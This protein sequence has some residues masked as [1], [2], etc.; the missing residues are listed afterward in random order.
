MEKY[1]ASIDLGASKI[2]VAVGERTRK[3]VKIRAYCEV[4]SNGMNRG[5]VENPRV[6]SNEVKKAISIIKSEYGIEVKKAIV[7]IAGHSLKCITTDPT[8]TQRD[9]TSEITY[10]EIV[11]ITKGM[12]DMVMED[13]EKVFCAI[14]QSYNVDNNMSVIQPEG[15]IGKTITSR[16]KL[17]VGKKSYLTLIDNVMNLA[18]VKV[19]RYIIEPIASAEAILTEEEKNGGVAVVDIGA[20][21]TDVVVIQGG[22]IRHVGIVPFGG[23]AITHDICEGC[24]IGDKQAEAI[25]VREGVCFSDYAGNANIVF[26]S[27]G[28]KDV[29]VT[30]K[31]L[32]NIIQARMEEILEAVRYIVE[33]SKFD[34]KLRVGY[35]FTG[36]GSKIQNLE[37]LASFILAK[38][39]RKSLPNK[40]TITEDSDIKVNTPSASTAVG[41]ILKGVQILEEEGLPFDFAEE[42][43]QT[44]SEQ[45]REKEFVSVEAV[46]NKKEGEVVK[47]KKQKRSL[48]ER[49]LGIQMPS[50]F[51][52]DD[53]G[54]EKEDLNAV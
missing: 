24:S 1:I 41:L 13:G 45:S 33:Q 22:I 15:M 49:F 47:E 38:N 6:V 2:A 43:I 23:D 5:Q 28:D 25:K 10:D 36:G 48:K 31:F 44:D 52:K 50:L 32:S 34:T 30:K 14:P 18:N 27:F 19:D 11:K 39:I 35:L 4:P 26:Q 37:N 46:A 29:Q 42:F 12:E 8:Q 7:G 3:G 17:V 9:S 40:F 21:S 51:N 54:D 16:F 20:G 53:D